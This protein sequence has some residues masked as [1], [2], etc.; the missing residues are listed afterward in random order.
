MC[1]P[2]MVTGADL[3]RQR[4]HRLIARLVDVARIVRAVSQVDRSGRPADRV[5]VPTLDRAAGWGGRDLGPPV[6]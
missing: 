1:G 4:L 2:L 3:L 5:A 6:S